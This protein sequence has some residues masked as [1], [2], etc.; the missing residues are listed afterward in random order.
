MPIFILEGGRCGKLYQTL[1]KSRDGLRENRQ[2]D[3]AGL[4]VVGL[5]DLSIVGVELGVPVF[6]GLVGTGNDV[7]KINGPRRRDAADS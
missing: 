1:E 4:Y 5:D 6:Q 3:D 2:K 7:F